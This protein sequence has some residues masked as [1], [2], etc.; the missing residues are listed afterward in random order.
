MG[1]AFDLIKSAYDDDEEK[2][3]KDLTIS[4]PARDTTTT[5]T[6]T[7]RAFE[8]MGVKRTAPSKE[9]KKKV[10][11]T[12]QSENTSIFDE[13]TNAKKTL[14]ITP[15]K[16]EGFIS[17]IGNA[18]KSLGN[19]FSHITPNKDPQNRNLQDAQ[20]IIAKMETDK[21]FLQKKKQAE[22]SYLKFPSIFPNPD[23]Q[24]IHTEGSP[25]LT[26]EAQ[27]IANK[28]AEPI[29]KFLSNPIDT[30]LLATKDFLTYHPKAQKTVS[31]VAKK[32]NENMV[33]V[34]VLR[35][36]RQSFARTLFGS[37]QILMNYYDKE[38][39]R[40]DI[41]QDKKQETVGHIIGG[42]VPYLAGGEVLSALELSPQV[43]MPILFNTFS[44]LSLPSRTKLIDRAKRVPIDT[45]LGYIF[46]YLPSLKELRGKQLATEALKGISIAASGTGIASY[47]ESLMQGMS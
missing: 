22:E 33:Q 28:N 9:A 37:S 36:A 21:L 45:T 18:I 44:Q 14:K 27:S 19:F 38:A 2:K 3:K 29:D 32:I 11:V 17:K 25:K 26:Q 30:T 16:S 46:S 6:S 40:T 31:D 47:L 7:S 23:V 42:L 39:I 20:D 5:P 1:R 15:K 41:P 35:S 34:P 12:P 8:L 43:A 10:D 24:L 4:S 13:Q